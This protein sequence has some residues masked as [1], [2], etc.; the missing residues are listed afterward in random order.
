MTYILNRKKRMIFDD[1]DM[2]EFYEEY[3]DFDQEEDDIEN[4][5]ENEFEENE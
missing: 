1:D 3:D 2:D 5:D 4:D